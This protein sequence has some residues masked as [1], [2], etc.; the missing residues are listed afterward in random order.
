MKKFSFGILLIFLF[1]TTQMSAQ[2]A[3]T[4]VKKKINVGVDIFTDMWTNLPSDMTT[5]KLNPSANVFATYNFLVGNKK[6]GNVIFSLGLGI[7][8]HVLSSKTNYISN[9]KADTIR[10]IPVP[11]TQHM[12]KSKMTITSLDVPAELKFKLKH[13]FH[14][15]IG[16][17]ISM[18]LRSK[19][20]Y[21]GTIASYADGITRQEK[22]KKIF[23][24]NSTCY[25][26]SI[27]LGYKNFDI[28]AAYQIIPT[29]RTGHGP[30]IHP[31]SLG[32]TITPF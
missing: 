13:G 30:D 7:G 29:F 26:P 20:S 16:F 31:F 1:A 9:V 28:Y 3:P 22:Y 32:I 10:F 25:T 12:K 14:M 27:R 6:N 19:E 24:L 5:R 21:T 4:T 17:K 2:V 8:T 15:G 11:T 23:Q 18:V